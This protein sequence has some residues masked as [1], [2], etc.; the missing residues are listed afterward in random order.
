MIRLISFTKSP[1]YPKKYRAVFML[2][3][4]HKKTTDFGD[5]RYEDYT[6]H[7]DRTRRANYIR[8]HR[9]DLGTTN[10]TKP[11]F[12]AMYVLWGKSTHVATNLNSYLKKFKIK[13]SLK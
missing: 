5:R 8:R 9:V 7:K 3:N 13:K 6:M 4:G 12:L 10:P 2:S 1:I 11:G